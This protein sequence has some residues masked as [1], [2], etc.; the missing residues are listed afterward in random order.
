MSVFSAKALR[1]APVTQ[2]LEP[3]RYQAR[4]VKVNRTASARTGTPGIE[5]EYQVT[6]GPIQSNGSDPRN[7]HVF[8][9]L[10]ASQDIDKL[11]PFLQRMKK[12]AIATNFDL[13]SDVGGTDDQFEEV[14]LAHLLQKE[15]VIKIGNEEYNGNLR[16]RVIDFYPLS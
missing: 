10:W 13:N 6:V 7:R 1:D 8:D 14:F 9:T 2:T 4:I 11:G 3:G 12:L 16:E 15:L 5:F